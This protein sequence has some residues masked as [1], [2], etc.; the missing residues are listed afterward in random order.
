MR[1]DP[2]AI[3][4]LA[5]TEYDLDRD[6]A[7]HKSRDLGLAY[8]RRR[9]AAHVAEAKRAVAAG[10][11]CHPSHFDPVDRLSPSQPFTGVVVFA[12]AEQALDY[13][14]HRF[15]RDPFAVVVVVVVVVRIVPLPPLS[16][17]R[18]PDAP[19]PSLGP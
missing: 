11:A 2:V 5:E 19:A 8:H 1:F 16:P 10:F 4:P 6:S 3:A 7:L 17:D 13:G 14:A 18:T 12:V 15:I 9:T